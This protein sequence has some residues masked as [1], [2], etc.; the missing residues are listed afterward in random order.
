MHLE[1]LKIIFKIGILD[2]IQELSLRTNYWLQWS[3][4]EYFSY[5]FIVYSNCIHQKS[6]IIITNSVP[7]V[8]QIT[9]ISSGLAVQAAG[10]NVLAMAKQ[11]QLV[12]DW[13][14]ASEDSVALVMLRLLEVQKTVLEGAGAIGLAPFIS[15][16]LDY[17]RGKRWTFCV[18][19]NFYF[20]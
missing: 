7:I 20:A 17:L 19:A 15:G 9:N 3:H 6:I 16:Q 4:S 11:Q 13:V 14:V 12:D 18:V 8:H 2:I 1:W 5:I 10:T